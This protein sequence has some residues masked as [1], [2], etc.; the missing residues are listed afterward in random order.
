M[1]TILLLLLLFVAGC[2]PSCHDRL[3]TQVMVLDTLNTFYQLDFDN[4]H[5]AIGILNLRTQALEDT[6]TVLK[7]RIKP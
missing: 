3:D 5:E 1:K 6:I 4:L 7:E 2:Q